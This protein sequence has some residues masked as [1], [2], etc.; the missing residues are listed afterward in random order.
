MV[1]DCLERET[2]LAILTFLHEI[3]TT[4]R[5]MHATVGPYRYVHLPYPLLF[6]TPLLHNIAPNH[7]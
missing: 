3:G 2:W 4:L 5:E 6:I 1:V 7:L